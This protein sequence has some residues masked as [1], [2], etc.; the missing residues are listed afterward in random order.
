MRPSR[1]AQRSAEVEVRTMTHEDTH[2]PDWL[3]PLSDMRGSTADAAPQPSTAR[4]PTRVRVVT[5]SASDILP[6][7]ARAIG[8]VVVPSRIIL[9][10]AVY[11]DGIDIT[12]AQF[13]AR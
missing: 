3:R 7:H 5:D 4:R 9:D 12:A 11:R 2:V 10:G 13:Y 1:G 6:S 8:I